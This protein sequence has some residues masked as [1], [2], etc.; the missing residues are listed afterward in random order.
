MEIKQRR[1]FIISL[2]KKKKKK[3]RK[4]KNIIPYAD[5]CTI[6]PHFFLDPIKKKKPLLDR[7]RTLMPF[8]AQDVSYWKSK[9]VLP[10]M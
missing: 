7:N 1:V 8:I 2:Q 5:L 6:G 10:W 4:K 9:E 3:R